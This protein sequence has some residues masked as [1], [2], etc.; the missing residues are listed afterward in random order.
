[1]N[2]RKSREGNRTVY[3]LVFFALALIIVGIVLRNRIGVLLDS[4]TESQTE[5]QARA[6][7]LIMSEKFDSELENLEYISSVLGRSLDDMDDMVPRIYVE[8]GIRQG[9]L[10]LDGE[11]LYGDRIDARKYRG[12]QDS[13]RGNKAITYVEN[14]GLLLTCPVY[15]G[16]NICYVLYRL[17]PFDVL[18]DYFATEIYEDQGKICVTTRDDD[19]VIPFY[20][21][22]DEDMAWFE[23][24]DIRKRFNQ[25]HM[26][27]EVSVAAA[28]TFNTDRG[29]MLLFESEI[30]DTDFLVSGYVP[31]AVASKGIGNIT[32]LVVWVFGLLMLLVMVGALYLTRVSIK[33]RESDELRE[34]KAIAEDA[35]KAKSDFLANM[36]HEIRTPIN[37]VLGMNEMILRESRDEA[38][39]GYASNIRNAGNTLLG[40]INDIL[41]F[42]KI[43]AGKIEIIPVEYD[44]S[45]VLYDLV[46]L[47]KNRAESKGLT[48]IY[49]FDRDIPKKLYGD[50]VRIKQIITNIITNAAKY[51]EKGSVTFTVGCEKTEEQE[52]E[53]VLNVAV[54]DTGI[55]IKPD[56]MKKLFSEFERIEEKRNRNIEGTGLGM[57]I[58]KSLLEKMDSHLE[59]SSEYGKGS[60]FSFSLKQKVMDPEPI[61]DYHEAYKEFSKDL[62][63]H[64]ESFRAPAAKILV[65]DD[66]FMNL[67]VFKNLVKETEVQIDTGDSGDDGIRLTLSQK[68]DIIFLDHMMPNKDGIETM[69]EIRGDVRNI[70]KDTPM[71]C[72]TA[73]AIAGAREEYLSAGFD[74]YLTKPIDSDEL[75]EMMIR[76]LPEEKLETITENEKRETP[77]VDDGI[78]ENLKILKGS[79]I[80]VS[81]G[82]KNNG[83]TDSYMTILR[84]FYDSID[85]KKH[86]LDEYYANKDYDNYRIK[87]HALKSS[88]R[89]IGAE[90]LGE[91]AQKLEDSAK[92]GDHD[93]INEHHEAFIQEYADLK[94][95]LKP[96][97]ED[98]REEEKTVADPAR[99]AK[100]YADIK[101]AA[102]D[103]DCDTLDKII[104]E[105]EGY[106]IPDD[107]SQLWEKLKTATAM[108]DYDSIIDLLSGIN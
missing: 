15:H 19:I 58:T 59:V 106:S 48:V 36:S 2:E 103:M 107:E 17:C 29:E 31:K 73:N 82:I 97:W 39:N 27:M 30:P 43:E 56:D 87:V 16:S 81:T 45:A 92:K 44:V 108:F 42:S 102:D 14:E 84:F 85:S 60:V 21:C 11:A 86:E 37:V 40:I 32:L 54:E 38:I 13:F 96:V 71:I 46:T 98:S 1:M 62:S 69:K 89:I 12:I 47:L 20:N 4:Y 104:E 22:S 90:E 23:S 75:E 74:D 105:M 57:S 41:D 3:V 63:E 99:I 77:A 50:E 5:E 64:R 9:L 61:G 83:G 91:L 72:L 53:V 93:F 79:Q 78:P 34:A 26:Q 76:Y 18:E 25:M 100:A 94:G 35:S 55:G 66:N 101:Q 24:K 70:N 80:D 52:D 6:Y 65:V 10:S 7:A 49:D 67:M 8:P 28:K 51:T 68:Y 88:I 95:L 33:A